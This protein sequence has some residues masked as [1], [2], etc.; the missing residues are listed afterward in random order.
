MAHW[1]AAWNMY[2][3]SPIVGIGPGGYVQAYPI[4]RVNDFWT[5]PLGHAHNIY[6]NILAESGFLGFLTYVG[7][8]IAW[9]AVVGGG[10]RR[11]QT[12]FDRALAAGV[13]ATL[14]GVA[15]HNLFDNLSVH[16]LETET[17]LLV[18]LCAAIGRGRISGSQEAA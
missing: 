15:F 3:A 10:F 8:L 11:S 2:Q 14:T 18:G 7:Q 17:G 6:L 12:G 13:L 4:F 16:G 9:V 1:Q 5:D